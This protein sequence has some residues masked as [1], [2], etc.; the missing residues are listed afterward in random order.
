MRSIVA[1][2]VSSALCAMGNP[3]AEENGSHALDRRGGGFRS[4]IPC[5]HHAYKCWDYCRAKY[6]GTCGADGSR[7]CNAIEHDHLCPPF[8][9]TSIVRRRLLLVCLPISTNNFVLARYGSYPTCVSILYND[10]LFRD[11]RLRLR[12]FRKI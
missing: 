7:V 4:D 11:A 5:N 3:A 9:D 6:G 2:L 12:L 8:P 10:G 1:I